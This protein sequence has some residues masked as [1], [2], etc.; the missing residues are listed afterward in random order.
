M[1][2]L[3]IDDELAL[4]DLPIAGVEELLF[5]GFITRGL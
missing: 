5:V 1:Q 3:A 4:A 2:S